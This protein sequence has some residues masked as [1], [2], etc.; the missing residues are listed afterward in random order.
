MEN[1]EMGRAFWSVSR[2]C[3][4]KPSAKASFLSDNTLKKGEIQQWSDMSVFMA[5]FINH[6]GRIRGWK[7]LNYKT[8]PHHTMIGTRELQKSVTG[9]MR[10]LAFSTPTKEL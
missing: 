8:Q 2:K 3:G 5:T 6:Q 4:L 1:I 7:I 10:H 9:E